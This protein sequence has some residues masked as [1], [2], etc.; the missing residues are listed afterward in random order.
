MGY[1]ILKFS[2]YG[3]IIMLSLLLAWEKKTMFGAK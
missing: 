1:L 2:I 3:E